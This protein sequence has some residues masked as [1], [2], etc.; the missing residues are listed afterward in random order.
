MRG[1]WITKI[2]KIGNS[3]GVILPVQYLRMLKMDKS[4][5]YVRVDINN[6]SNSIVIAKTKKPK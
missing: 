1:Q 2:I 4:N 5:Q 3:Y 6:R